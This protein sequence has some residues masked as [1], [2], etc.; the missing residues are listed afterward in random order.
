MN[1]R[2]LERLYIPARRL[3]EPASAGLLYKALLLMYWR[4]EIFRDDQFPLAAT[5]CSQFIT[6][7]L[8]CEIRPAI[9]SVAGCTLVPTYSYARLYFH[10]NV[11]D[12]HLDRDAC[13]VSASVNLGC[14]GGDP[15]LWFDPNERVD[16]SPGDGVVYLGREAQHWRPPFAGSV[17]GQLFLHYVVAD[18]AYVE[19]AFD[20]H[21]ERFPPRAPTV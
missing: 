6:D 1:P 9:E 12:R 3:I 10:G 4:G 17:M 2:L 13:E 11:L 18:G 21:S 14:D 15:A 19:E 7:A 20:R 8:L 16:M 5:L